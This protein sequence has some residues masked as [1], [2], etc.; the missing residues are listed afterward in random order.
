LKKISTH[1]SSTLASKFKSDAIWGMATVTTPESKE[2][3]RVVQE[4]QEMMIIGFPSAGVGAVSS[5]LR[6]SNGRSS[7]GSAQ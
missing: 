6:W 1:Q 3:I 2:P 4:I 5:T 7:S